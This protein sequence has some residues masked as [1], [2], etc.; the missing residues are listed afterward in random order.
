MRSRVGSHVHSGFSRPFQAKEKESRREYRRYQICA[1]SNFAIDASRYEN[2]ARFRR[3]V[4]GFEKRKSR[5]LR[6]AA[7]AVD[8]SQGHLS[9][10]RFPRLWAHVGRRHCYRASAA[11]HRRRRDDARAYVVVSPNPFRPRA[12]SPERVN[13]SPSSSSCLRSPYSFRD[14]FVTLRVPYVSAPSRLVERVGANE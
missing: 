13:V 12:R 9:T 1:K 4:L 5:A 11:P 2:P 7:Y 10:R 6:M 14:R 8:V 3:R